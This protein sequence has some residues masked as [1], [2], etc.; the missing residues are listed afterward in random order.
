MINVERLTKSFRG[1]KNVEIAVDD[2]SFSVREGEFF[3]LLGPSG[4][5]KTTTLRC[6]AGLEHPD[7]GAIHLGE[8][9][10]FRDRVLVPSH[11]RDIGM[12]FQSYAV[13]PH[14]SVFENVAFPL[15]VSQE[16]MTRHQV[17][18]EVRDVLELVGL[19]GLDERMSTDLSGGQQQRLAL[20]R[21]LVRKPTVLLLDEPLSNLDARLR[22]RMRM[23]LR[24]IQKRTGLT[25]LFV[26]HDQVEALSMSDR[27]AVM[28]GGRIVQVA[29][30]QEFY[31]QP[32]SAFVATFLGGVN[33][34]PGK[35]VRLAP[36][37]DG[38]GTHAV[39][40]VAFGEVT[41]LVGSEGLDVGD[42]VVAAIR[43][44]DVRVRRATRDEELEENTFPGQVAGFLY[45]GASFDYHVDVGDHEIRARIGSRNEFLE[46]GATV[47]TTFPARY[48]RVLTADDPAHQAAAPDG[49]GAADQTETVRIGADAE[50]S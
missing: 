16:R 21:A 48:L 26:T 28:S 14:L 9:T 7:S 6:I 36:W 3:T 29:T 13:W 37:P 43:Y 41:G 11:R 25:T 47:A 8:E 49:A 42:S 45:E 5:G 15:R 1:R 27:M 46:D 12:V 40:E 35:I 19:H 30:P 20:A 2:V 24:L 33:L 39:V 17:K 31:T 10:V 23:E 4:C 18:A 38:R 22:E 32:S 50:A 44:E 34:L